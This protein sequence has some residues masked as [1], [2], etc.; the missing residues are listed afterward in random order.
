MGGREWQP[1][2]DLLLVFY[3]V[4]GVRYSTIEELFCLDDFKRTS[5]AVSE[6]IRVLRKKE[7]IGQ[8]YSWD[9]DATGIWFAQKLRKCHFSHIVLPTNEKQDLVNESS[10]LRGF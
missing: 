7:N 10:P 4:A 9:M 8:P 5:A 1:E 2:E 3:A 6:R